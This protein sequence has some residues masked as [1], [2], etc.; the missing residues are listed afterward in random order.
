MTA[1]DAEVLGEPQRA[2]KAWKT[3][4]RI[5]RARAHEQLAAMPEPPDRVI[6]RIDQV[7]QRYPRIL[8]SG[9]VPMK[10]IEE[11]M[12]EHEYTLW[13]RVGLL[14]AVGGLGYLAFQIIKGILAQ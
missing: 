13:E 10:E 5:H 9:E 3:A 2:T 4:R 11:V 14:L 7:V 12:E 1:V 6:Q 8:A